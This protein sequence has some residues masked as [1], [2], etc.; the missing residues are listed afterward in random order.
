MLLPGKLRRALASQG[1]YNDWSSAASGVSREAADG[2]SPLQRR[3][4]RRRERDARAWLVWCKDGRVWWHA[5]TQFAGRKTTPA[6]DLNERSSVGSGGK[7]TEA[8]DACSFDA[9][10]P[11]HGF[12]WNGVGPG[13]HEVPWP[14]ETRQRSL[15]VGTVV[16]S[17][18]TTCCVALNRRR[19]KPSFSGGIPGA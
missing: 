12:G 6:A 9:A 16:A 19:R 4:M 8:V 17:T 15:C 10:A 11:G 1:P 18:E 7:A 13:S 2:T 5:S 14:G 3:V